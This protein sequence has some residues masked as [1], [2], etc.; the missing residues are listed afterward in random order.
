M[1]GLLYDGTPEIMADFASQMRNLG[2]RLIGSC[3]GS[4][5]EH[6]RAMNAA[7]NRV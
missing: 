7:L 3:C 2:V 6:I 1:K 4:T 5:P